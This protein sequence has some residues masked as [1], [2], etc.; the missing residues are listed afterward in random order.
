[1]VLC[2]LSGAWDLWDGWRISE[3]SL[4]L[5]LRDVDGCSLRSSY[6]QILDFADTNEKVS[7]YNDFY[8]AHFL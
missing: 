5:L 4:S 2:K 3:V 8:V 6:I 7:S 1:M